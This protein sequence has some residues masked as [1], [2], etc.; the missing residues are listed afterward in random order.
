MPHVRRPRRILGFLAAAAAV[1]VVSGS[2]AVPPAPGVRHAPIHVRR[3]PDGTPQRGLRNQLVSSNWSGYA[4]A[5]YQTGQKYTSAQ[6]TWVVPAVAYGSSTDT[7]S[8]SEYSANWVGIGGFCL[9]ALC[10]RGDRTLIQLGTEQDVA[11]S[12]SNATQYYAW[13]EMLPAAETPL[14]SNYVVKPG[15]TITA[16]LA[17]V[18]ACTARKQSWQ[19]TITNQTE[20]W[21]WTT[22]VGYGSS[23]ASAEWIEEAPYSGGILP[24]ADFGTASFSA[25][26]GADGATPSLSLSTNGI[27]MQ[28]PWGQTSTPSATDSLADFNACWGFQTYTSCATP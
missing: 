8:S 18:A 27:E 26:S 25:T 12:P 16:S 6:L 4:V 24:L 10:T 14:P 7:T 17:C 22:K 23:L 19:L 20:G 28:D 21:N 11:P 9:N 2:V 3:N 15:D 5:N 13:Y 1:A